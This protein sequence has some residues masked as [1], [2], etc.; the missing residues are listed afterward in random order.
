MKKWEKPELKDLELKETKME[1]ECPNISLFTPIPNGPNGV[2]NCPWWN[3]MGCIHKNHN[4]NKPDKWP[5]TQAI[6][7]S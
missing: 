2:D 3:G 7:V 4:S 1:E 6:A 5:C